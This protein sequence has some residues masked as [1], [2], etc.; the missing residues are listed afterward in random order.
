MT[1]SLH[2]IHLGSSTRQSFSVVLVSDCAGNRFSEAPPD[3]T[4]R[5][6]SSNSVF[7]YLT[8]GTKLIAYR[9]GFSYQ[10]FKNNVRFPLLI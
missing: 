4:L 2:L 3:A 6:S 10:S 9:L 8:N 1:I 7:D 5:Q